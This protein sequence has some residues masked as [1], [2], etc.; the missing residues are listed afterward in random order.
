MNNISVTVKNK[1]G[2]AYG[3]R[4]IDLE[5]DDQSCG[6]VSPG[7]E[8]V[9]PLSDGVL[10][11][12]GIEAL[13]P[14]D[15][16]RRNG[17][18]IPITIDSPGNY[19]ISNLHH[20]SRDKWRIEFEAPTSTVNRTAAVQSTKPPVTVT[21]GQDDPDWSAQSTTTK[22]LFCSGFS[23]C[24][25]VALTQVSNILGFAV[26]GVLVLGGIVSWLIGKKKNL[27]SDVAG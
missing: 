6:I 25:A 19:V 18:P 16:S 4:T 3:N 10:Q 12:L 9:L 17:G 23:S 26:S 15:S 24:V 27:N 2:A 7:S 8:K 20:E 21:V 11:S 1:L 14:Q 5:E 13:P 22:V